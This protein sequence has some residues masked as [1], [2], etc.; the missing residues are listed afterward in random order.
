MEHLRL[1]APMVI[2]G[3]TSQMQ[4]EYELE[5]FANTLRGHKITI[6]HICDSEKVRE[7]DAETFFESVAAGGEESLWW[8]IK[9][10]CLNSFPRSSR[11]VFSSLCRGFYT[12]LP[13]TSCV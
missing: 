8:K 13:A 12:G 5:Y 9:V 1:G 6:V 10:L 2:R 3:C 7:I 4:R 11:F